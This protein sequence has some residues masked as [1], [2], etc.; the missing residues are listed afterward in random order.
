MHAP[1]SHNSHNPSL[2][3]FE[4]LPHA[5]TSCGKPEPPY[6]TQWSDV[7]VKYK[8]S[9]KAQTWQL[10]PQSTFNEYITGNLVLNTSNNQYVFSALDASNKI[11]TNEYDAHLN[12]KIEYTINNAFR[13]SVH[14][15]T[16]NKH[17]P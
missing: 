13:S 10:N 1:Y 7:V 4:V 6:S 16:R 12:V 2:W 5:Q 9:F 11:A 17:S 8:E 3:R 14:E 15:S